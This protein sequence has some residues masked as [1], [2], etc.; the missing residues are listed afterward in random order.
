VSGYSSWADGALCALHLRYPLGE[1]VATHARADGYG[2]L[3]VYIMRQGS[4]ALILDTGFS[5]HEREVIEGLE[6][7]LGPHGS[8]SV[9]P[10]RL[11][12]YD[13]VCNVVPILR[14]FPVDTVY[15]AQRGGTTWLDFRPDQPMGDCFDSVRFAYVRGSTEIFL[16]D[17]QRKIVT[18]QPKFRLLTTHWL[19]D[20][21]SRTLFTSDVFS[22]VSA[23]TPDGPWVINSA[24]D[25]TTVDD[26]RAH[27]FGTRYWWLQGARTAPLVKWVREIFDTYQVHRIAPAYGAVLDG[28]AVV[29]RHVDLL[30]DVLVAADAQ[31]AR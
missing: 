18:L 12:E 10:L 2:V 9:F 31:P 27:L 15:A 30:C 7:I 29:S 13:S 4:D 19:Y 25:G 1:Q 5:I 17:G 22:H 16:G 28:A 21:L 24:N 26:I 14:R 23:S 8:L 3:N 6:S 20:E 11:G